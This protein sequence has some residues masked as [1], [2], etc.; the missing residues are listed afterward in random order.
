MA[1]FGNLIALMGSAH[2]LSP[3]DMP[4]SYS[5]VQDPKVKYATQANDLVPAR[6]LTL[7][8]RVAVL[9]SNDQLHQAWKSIMGHDFDT[10]DKTVIE[11]PSP[12][13]PDAPQ[14]EPKALGTT[15]TEDPASPPGKDAKEPDNKS[16][17]FPPYRTLSPT[18]LEG[19]HIRVVREGTFKPTVKVSHGRL[20]GDEGVIASYTSA[21]LAHQ[22][23][24]EDLGRPFSYKHGDKMTVNLGSLDADIPG[25]HTM[26]NRA[27]INLPEGHAEQDPDTI[28]H[29]MGHGI[30]EANRPEI[31]PSM[32]AGEAHEAFADSF[33]MLA[34]LEDPAVRKDVISRRAQGQESNLAS[35][36]GEGYEVDVHAQ[37]E[38]WEQMTSLTSTAEKQ[39][40]SK[41]DPR[42]SIRDLSQ[43][44]SRGDTADPHE[45]GMR[46]GHATYKSVLALSDQLR[47]DDPK[48]S[49]DAAL[50]TA[51]R[52]VRKDLVRS[53][54][55]MPAGSTLT[56]DSMAQALLRADQVD[57]QGRNVDLLT[58]QFKAAGI[59][60]NPR[61]LAD[62]KARI[63][64]LTADPSLALPSSLT[65][66]GG[67][68]RNGPPVD[69]RGMPNGAV[70]LTADTP[71]QEAADAYLQA[72]A[73][74]LGITGA[75]ALQ[76]QELYHNNRGET[77]IYY[78]NGRDKYDIT[79][80]QHAIL[81]FDAQGKL[82]FESQGTSAD[83]SKPLAEPAS[84][85]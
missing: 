36:I 21:Q 71:E 42:D 11:P 31:F 29:E 20:Q 56:Q 79:S 51:A 57:N 17:S 49:P 15:A 75:E 14:P 72:H 52:T 76:A 70:P 61:E 18:Q 85:G 39:D 48:L 37:K 44:S 10:P 5:T 83:L 45:A 30:L 34:S 47:K 1:F 22:M 32:G 16:V 23:A 66:G 33:A 26:G 2:T 9:K 40:G 80:T 74:K 50:Q 82:L 38:R 60:P 24:S 63:I 55:F 78:S 27:Q 58:Q 54:D 19:D 46:F 59:D 43:T 12:L 64:R 7:Q 25:P 81:G 69:D 84:G 68:V 3:K 62:N 53:M 8:G 41:P 65:Q 6:D 4:D 35:N 77:F 73:D 13:P 28:T 67:F